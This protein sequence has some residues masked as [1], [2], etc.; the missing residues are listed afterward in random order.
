MR[1]LS[2]I[3]NIDNQ[4][5]GVYMKKVFYTLLIFFFFSICMPACAAQSVKVAAL[6]E[7]NS[8]RPVDT[9]RVIV[10]ERV[11]FKNGIVFEDGT[12]VDGQI[13]DV[14]QPKR[15][16]LNASFKFRPT[17]YRYNGKVYKVE[18]PEFFAKYAEYKELD[19][20]ALAT[21][22]A[23]TAGGLIFHIPLLSEGVSLVKGMWKN[24]ENNRLKSGVVQ[25]YKDSPLSYIEEGKDIEIKKDTMFIFKF[26]SSDAEDLDAENTDAAMVED[27][28]SAQNPEKNITNITPVPAASVEIQEPDNTSVKHIQTVDPE[29]VLR[30]VELNTSKPQPVQ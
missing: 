28:K 8:L 20:A 29:E 24:P 12:V 6:T 16:K 30:E 25:V 23:T 22:A 26:K 27:D 9:M 1:K 7:F 18:D 13:F 14:K 15:A 17:T 19:K 10:L 4:L 2:C 21:S 3:I 5:G 11:E